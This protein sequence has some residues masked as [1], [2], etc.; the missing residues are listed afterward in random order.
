MP[1]RL[2]ACA[3]GACPSGARAGTQPQSL[4][5]SERRV[6][7]KRVCERLIGVSLASVSFRHQANQRELCEQDPRATAAERLKRQDARVWRLLGD[8]A[9]EH[10]DALAELADERI[11][12][13]ISLSIVSPRGP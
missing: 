3:S 7:F 2:G 1:L 9:P 13:L 10:Q 5:A 8:G 4:G 6:S 12:R 11:A